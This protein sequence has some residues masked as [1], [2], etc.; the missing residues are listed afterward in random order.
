MKNGLVYQ[1]INHEL[2]VISTCFTLLLLL[3]GWSNSFIPSVELGHSQI[4]KDKFVEQEKLA[5]A[6]IAN[7]DYKAAA[8]FLTVMINMNPSVKIIR[9]QGQLKVPTLK[10]TTIVRPKEKASTRP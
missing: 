8:D 3:L 5:L 9:H 7:Q 10:S 1:V 6:S 4:D 2:C